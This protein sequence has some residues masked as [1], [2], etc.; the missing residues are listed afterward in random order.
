MLFIGM[1]GN[2]RPGKRIVFTAKKAKQ[3]GPGGPARRKV[4]QL[5]QQYGISIRKH[6]VAAKRIENIFNDMEG[7]T[8][9]RLGELN[10]D[11][12]KAFQ[13]VLDWET[14]K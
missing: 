5:F 13:T 2:K 7:E 4:T 6:S 10:K 8:G 14:K 12:V 3:F 11:F 1:G 9:R